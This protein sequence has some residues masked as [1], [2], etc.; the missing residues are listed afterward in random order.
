MKGYQRKGFSMK[1]TNAEIA[2]LKEALKFGI[3][4]VR[5]ATAQYKQRE[6]K[7]SDMQALS[8][9]LTRMAKEVDET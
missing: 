1:L 4:Y 7:I 3:Y 6:A 5:A 8:R 2:M 9:K